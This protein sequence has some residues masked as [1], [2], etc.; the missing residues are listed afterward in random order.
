MNLRQDWRWLAAVLLV[1]SVPIAPLAAL[2]WF[3]LTADLN[4]WPHLIANVLPSALRDTVALL[5]GVGIL[6]SAIGVTT[7]W[8]V[9]A[10]EFPGRRIFEWALLLPLAMPAY[11]VAYTYV[12]ILDS[13]GPLQTLLRAVTGYTS[14]Q[15]Y[16][17]P[18]PR[19]LP[20]AILLMGFVLYPYVYLTARA[21]FLMQAAGL[22]DVA[23]TLGDDARGAFWR[24]AL[25]LARPA[26]A[27]GVTL[28]LMEAMNDI[29]A[30]EHLGVRTLTVSVYTTWINRGSLGGAAQIA[31]LTLLIVVGLVALER[32]A[33]RR[34]RFAA[35]AQRQRR[36]VPQPL[37][38]RSAAV[39]VMICATPILLGFVAPAAYLIDSAVRHAL[40][41]GIPPG[42]LM[43]LGH[44]V[45]LA[46]VAAVIAVFFGLILAVAA[47]V[48]RTPG[49]SFL[50][51]LASLGYAAPGTILAVG[52]LAPLA[53]FDNAVDAFMRGS[54]G[55]STGLLLSGTGVALVLAYVARFL[56]IANGGLDAGLGRVPL[57]LDMA[58]R[59][60]GDT[61]SQ[62]MW[63]IHLPL[64]RPALGAAALLV[65][66]DAMKE[67][68]ATLLLRPFN[69]ETLSTVVYDAASRGAFE[70]GALAALAIVL[71]GLLPV[72]MISRLSRPLGLTASGAP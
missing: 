68:P 13:F 25:P 12:E 30:V 62:A 34:Q 18:E 44:T 22:I 6:V 37:R 63:R 7:A 3:A 60:L 17:F 65:F 59:N 50:A 57:S 14:R 51:R 66:V 33:R 40:R 32:Y 41:Q 71:A 4:V 61:R 2:A 28:A 21:M 31:C 27:V 26:I 1:A 16:W 55:I 49:V 29:G 15:D 11:I 70:E 39:V 8:L 35:N 52:M 38:G 48:T 20:G 43:A 72:V 24:I 69:F 45:M 46:S 54:V 10:H 19:S 42:F 5:V 53:A 9:A 47:R 67:L 36:L 58:A 64:I 56:G 23:R